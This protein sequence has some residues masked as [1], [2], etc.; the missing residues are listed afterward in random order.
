V[1]FVGTFLDVTAKKKIEQ[2]RAALLAR[3]QEARAEAETARARAE[4]ASR[5]K[6]EFLATV[7]H[8][9]RNPLNAILGWSRVL[10]EEDQELPRERQRK[11]LEVIARNAKAQVQLVEDIL[12]VSRIVSGKLRLST[13]P[14]DVRSVV[15]AAVDTVRSAAQ[16][17]GVVLETRVDPETGKIVA[18]EDRIQQVLWNL[19]SNAVKFT[20]RGGSVRLDARR[21]RDEVV[22]AVTDT[23]EGVDSEFLPFVFDRFRQAD[24]S[25]TRSHGGLGLG[26]AIVR[27]LVELHGGTVC[28]DSDGAGRGAT[29][30]VRLPIH[31]EPQSDDAPRRVVTAAKVALDSSMDARLADIHVLVLDDEE[32]MRDLIS[33]ILEHAGA[34]VTRVPTVDAA[35]KAIAADCPDVAVSDLAMPGEDGY[36]FVKRVRAWDDETLRALPLVAMTAYARAEDR[37]RVLAAGFQRHVAKPIEPVELVDALAEI[38]LATRIAARAYRA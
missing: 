4:A 28:A 8:E 27:H 37:H 34:R 9:L 13:G 2:E 3:E 24:G 38:A 1:R 6:D 17:K 33:M 12:E 23:G 18:D 20:P 22:L 11:G 15:E 32:D 31:A 29:F 10:L 21:D 36:A 14:T 35:L 25:T 7:S 26:L 19:L 16:A 5:A 30:T